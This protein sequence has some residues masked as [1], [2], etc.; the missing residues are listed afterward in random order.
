MYGLGD[1]TDKRY[2]DNERPETVMLGIMWESVRSCSRA[3]RAADLT[4]LPILAPAK[5]YDG[6]KMNGLSFCK[7]PLH[8]HHRHSI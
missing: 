5:G 6:L 1:N 4:I 8:D 3:G 7:G 2:E